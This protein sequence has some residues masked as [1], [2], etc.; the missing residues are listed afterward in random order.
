MVDAIS[1][2]QKKKIQ[3]IYGDSADVLNP[4]PKNIEEFKHTMECIEKTSSKTV[5]KVVTNKL[6]ASK[7]MHI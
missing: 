5:V 2:D 4:T 7:I 1:I 6:Y 3:S